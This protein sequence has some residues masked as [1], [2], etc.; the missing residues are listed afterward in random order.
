MI[1]RRKNQLQ[2][3]ANLF[4]VVFLHALLPSLPNACAEC[5]PPERPAISLCLRRYP[6]PGQSPGR[7]ALPSEP[8]SPQLAVS[9]AAARLRVGS[10]P[11]PPVARPRR[12]KPVAPDRQA[13]RL[14]NAGACAADD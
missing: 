3:L 2:T 7:S 5:A 4:N 14:R 13:T 10:A 9:P 11:V 6:A 1:D 8:A 12:A